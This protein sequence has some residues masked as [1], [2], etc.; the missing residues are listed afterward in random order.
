MAIFNSYVK[1]PEG[2]YKQFWDGLKPHTRVGFM[3]HGL[4]WWTFWTLCFCCQYLRL[5]GAL[6][7][8]VS[9]GSNT[10]NISDSWSGKIFSGLNASYFCPIWKMICNYHHWCFPSRK[11][12]PDAVVRFS[13]QML[14][15]FRNQSALGLKQW[16][17]DW[18]MGVYNSWTIP[19]GSPN[20][21]GRKEG[22]VGTIYLF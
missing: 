7:E 6:R 2:T 8:T 18:W 17:L 21:K 3:S 15:R 9:V 12:P 22:N 13:G 19:Y 1:L 16:T 4:F 10:R 5:F 14:D 20:I 11:P